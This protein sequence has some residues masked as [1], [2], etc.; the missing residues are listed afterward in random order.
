VTRAQAK[1]YAAWLAQMTRKP[2]R[3]LTEAEWEYAARAGATTA[4]SWGDEIGEGHANCDGCGSKWDRMETSPV[5][6]FPPNAFGLYD[7][8]GDVWQWVEDCRH[9]NYEG[10]PA[11]NSEWTGGDCAEHV[12]RGGSWLVGPQFLRPAI[13]GEFPVEDH[14]SD[15]GFRV[16]RTLTP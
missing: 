11:D 15:I 8:A 2:Y 12:V 4:Y 16:A 10:A 3:L 6:T 14:N 5:G 9:A 13:R 7:M 1:Q